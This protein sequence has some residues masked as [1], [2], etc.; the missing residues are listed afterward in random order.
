MVT[1]LHFETLPISRTPGGF[2]RTRRD[3]GLRS[4]FISE[5]KVTTVIH[6]GH[7]SG[8]ICN[9]LVYLKEIS[10]KLARL[11]LVCCK[12]LYLKLVCWQFVFLKLVCLLLVSLELIC[13]EERRRE[14]EEE[15]DK[16]LDSNR[17]HRKNLHMLILS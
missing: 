6:L 1:L 14:K 3:G 17:K 5:L 2:T 13:E 9:A 15:E 7:L 10:L 16:H 8:G 12:L 4:T 11:K